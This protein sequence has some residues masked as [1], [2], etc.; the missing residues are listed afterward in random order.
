MKK[1]IVLSVLALNINM[2]GVIQVPSCWSDRSTDH[3]WT[4]STIPQ[5]SFTNTTQKALPIQFNYTAANDE[6]SNFV[7]SYWTDP[8]CKIGG[9]P[10]CERIGTLSPAV[11]L[12]PGETVTTL[13]GCSPDNSGFVPKLVNIEINGVIVEPVIKT[14]YDVTTKYYQSPEHEY[15]TTQYYISDDGI[16]GY[17]L[18]TSSSMG[19]TTM[20][21]SSKEHYQPEKSFKQAS[22][23]ELFERERK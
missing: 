13:S 18:G 19:K 6:G 20:H 12:Q 4:I 11:N 17:A 1:L 9:E 22:T 3:N 21:Y 14:Y 23:K 16:G 15:P 5:I 2:Y 8:N 7:Q 10:K